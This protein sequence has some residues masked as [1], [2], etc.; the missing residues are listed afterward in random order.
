MMEEEFVRRRSWLTHEEF[1][2]MIG[3]ANLVP[4]PNSTE[5]AIHLGLQRAGVLGMI[6]A[7]VCFILPAALIVSLIAWSYVRLGTLPSFQS[8]LYGIKAVVVAVVAQAILLLVSKVVNTWAK[9]AA[10]AVSCVCAFLAINEVIVLFVSGLALGSAQLAKTKDWRSAKPLLGLLAA[11][12]LIAALPLVWE[13]SLASGHVSTLSLF[14]YFLK[15]GSVLYGSGYVLLAFL[16]HDLVSHWH[17]LSKGQLLDA[18]AVGQF[19]PGP[20]FTTATF[21][22]YILGGPMGAAVSTIGIFLPSFFFVALS[23]R[24]LPVLRESPVSSGFL[25]G[26]NAAA[27]A[28]MVVVL[29]RLGAGAL[30]DVPTLLISAVSLALLLRW[31]VNSA[32]LIGVGGFVGWLVRR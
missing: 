1:V 14:L 18:I 20:V 30:V 27:L 5:V 12:G 21:I 17:W 32:I 28:L 10:F 4:G 23:G 19:T 11:V 15:V 3:A 6:T 31:R 2:D 7:G 24:Y 9:R 22:G 13:V 8:A 29:Y 16:D 26:V 25:D